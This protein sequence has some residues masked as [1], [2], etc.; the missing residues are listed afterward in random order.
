MEGE[1]F[2]PE[3]RARVGI[4]AGSSRGPENGYCGPVGSGCDWR[5]SGHPPRCWLGLN[6]LVCSASHCKAQVC[7]AGFVDR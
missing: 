3:V 7:R 6:I 4:G 1:N 5:V 2:V